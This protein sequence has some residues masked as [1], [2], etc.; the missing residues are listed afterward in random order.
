MKSQYSYT[1]NGVTY[2]YDGTNINSSWNSAPSSSFLS[3]S[4]LQEFNPA[5][6]T[7]TLIS[8]WNVWPGFVTHPAL[9]NVLMF[10]KGSAPG[11][12]LEFFRWSA[13][14]DNS[15]YVLSEPPSGNYLFKSF[16]STLSAPTANWRHRGYNWFDLKFDVTKNASG[17]W[18][19]P[20][21]ATGPAY[22]DMHNA[23]NS[24]KIATEQWHADGAQQFRYV[25]YYPALSEAWINQF[26]GHLPTPLEVLE[27]VHGT[28]GASGQVTSWEK[29][30]YARQ[31]LANGS[32][33]YFG[34][35]RWTNALPTWGYGKC[36]NGVPPAQY[37]NASCGDFDLIV[38]FDQPYNAFKLASGSGY[39]TAQAYLNSAYA[40]T[41]SWKNDMKIT[42]RTAVE[43]V[44]T[45]ST[46]AAND[47]NYMPHLRGGFIPQGNG[48]DVHGTAFAGS[49]TGGGDWVYLENSLV[50]QDWYVYPAGKDPLYSPQSSP[51]NYCRDGYQYRGSLAVSKSYS[52]LSGQVEDAGSPHW[53]VLCATSDEMYVNAS[54]AGEPSCAT[55]YTNRSWWENFSHAGVWACQPG[56]A[57]ADLSSKNY[58][59]ICVK[60]THCAGGASA[61]N[62]APSSYR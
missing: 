3:V 9:P 5:T 40:A 24:E 58:V 11:Q 7:K 33:N 15:M 10:S 30:Y 27:L 17:V 38:Q 54:N 35:I 46:S 52:G 21:N 4:G 50:D 60:N 47:A 57:C 23:P 12:G 45:N 28:T 53:I 31:K 56:Q 18:L 48:N 34:L 55:G 20:R 61:C 13:N 14:P 22:Y 51:V 42:R 62:P 59:N 25:N 44:I 6:N 49:A 26:G 37:S 8:P 1:Y 43:P 36:T 19:G 2:T 16:G 41:R 32:Y 29:Y 39:P